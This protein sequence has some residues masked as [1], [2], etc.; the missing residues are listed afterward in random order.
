MKRYK[1]KWA[2]EPTC[3]PTNPN[4]NNLPTNR[5]TTMGVVRAVKI[6]TLF[7][8]SWINIHGE[9]DTNDAQEQIIFGRLV[10]TVYCTTSESPHRTLP[11][12]SISQ[13]P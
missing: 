10:F 13:V 12:L 5:P 9:K 1:N 11:W 3:R 8:V 4:S 2:S 7:K 6:I